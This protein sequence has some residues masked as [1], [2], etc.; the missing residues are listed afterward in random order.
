MS[1][2]IIPYARKGKGQTTS[3][4]DP[5]LLA[6]AANIYTKTEIDALSATLPSITADFSASVAVAHLT[7]VLAITLPSI[8][9]SFEGT[10]VG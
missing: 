10:S 9:A 7:A 6:L 4:I 3:G 2:F 8:I 1:D 5:D